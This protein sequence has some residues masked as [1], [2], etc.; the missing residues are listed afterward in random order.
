[1]MSPVSSMLQQYLNYIL[2]ARLA[3]PETIILDP[4]PAHQ[5]KPYVNNKVLAPL[6]A[7][8]TISSASLDN[9]DSNEETELT[10]P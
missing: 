6:G 5:T 10:S 7:M 4:F 1:M 9:E 2:T 3:S 8:L